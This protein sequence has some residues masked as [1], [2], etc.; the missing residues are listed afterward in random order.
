[1]TT[2]PPLPTLPT[3]SG[4]DPGMVSPDAWNALV[5]YCKAL[6]KRQ[7]LMTPQT[8]A[9][10][11]MTM[12]PGGF[13]AALKRRA[14]NVDTLGP[15]W[16]RFRNDY[17]DP[18]TFKVSVTRGVVYD[19]A[20]G[21]GDP[22]SW[23]ECPNQLDEDDNIALF[24]IT[25][26]QCVYVRYGREAATDAVGSASGDDVRIEVD[27]DGLASLNPTLTSAGYTYVKLAKFEVND[28]GTFKITYFA[29]GDNVSHFRDPSLSLG[30][31]TGSLSLSTNNGYQT[32]SIIE[33]ENGLITTS[34]DILAAFSHDLLSVTITPI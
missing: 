23:H 30:G 9:D 17:D 31:G 15:F 34:G 25:D 20:P 2:L 26:G 24:T 7:E 6:A 27:A 16:P 1:M 11:A 5:A 19:H 4:M 32:F 21:S 13:S 29:A 8:S 12:G 33:W 28:D 10:I 22:I 3:A 14:I 18:D